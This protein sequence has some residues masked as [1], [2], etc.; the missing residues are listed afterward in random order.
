ML[1]NPARF[2]PRA[3]GLEARDVPSAVVAADQTFDTTQVGQLPAGWAAWANDRPGGFAVADRVALSPA[4]GLDATGG[5][6]TESRAWAD[7]VLTYDAEVSAAVFAGSLVPATVF[8][9]GQALDTDRPSY[10]GASVTRGLGVQVVRVVG[11]ETTVLGAVKSTDYVSQKW[12]KVTL[13]VVGTTVEASVVRTDTNAFLTPAG[14]WQADPVAAL[15]ATDDIIAGAGRAG[16]AR[17]ARYAGAVTFDDF[18]AVSLGGN[19]APVLT[20]PVVELTASQPAE[21][22]TGS[23]AFTV[24]AE[25]SARVVRVEFKLDGRTLHAKSSAP[26]DWTFD[27]ATR[28]PGPH[29]LVVRAIDENGQV[30]TAAFPFT[31]AEPETGRPELA[32]KFDHV[33]IAQLAYSSTPFGPFEADKVATAVDL[34]IPNVKFLDTIDAADPDVPQLIYTNVSN[35]YL[36]LLADWSNY[37]DAAGVSREAAFYH[38]AEPTA[39]RFASG[40]AYPVNRFWDV[41]LTDPT[42]PSEN[43]TAVAYTA[44]R[45]GPTFPAAGQSMLI[46]YL[47][48]F[49]EINFDLTRGASRGGPG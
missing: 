28:E 1:T 19:P 46:G 9:R 23:I 13:S 21:G 4:R 39:W 35:V 25:V 18:R 6:A 24:Q 22:V 40:S 12:V 14:R 20:P 11:G 7:P 3:E 33:R 36:D 49:R 48:E 26:A 37:A 2:R 8:A 31:I 45:P 47:D 27:T 15:T 34:V 10:Y 17:P 30:G 16:L 42:G 29:E 5:S 41:A 43:V 32:R 44:S 38:V